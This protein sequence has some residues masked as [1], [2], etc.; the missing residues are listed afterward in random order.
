M[1]DILDHP[2][3]HLLFT[4]KGG[5]GKTSLAAAT[6]VA[7]AD[8]GRSV[9]LVSTDPASNL[10]QALECEVGTRVSPVPSVPGL[11][12]VN[13]DPAAA[14]EAYRER[15]IG[16]VRGVLP[17]DAVEQM[18]ESLSGACTTEIA[19]FD[20]FTGLLTDARLSR[21]FDH[22]VF[23]TAPTGHT[24]RLLQLPAAWS[25]FIE[26]NPDGAS[27]LGPASGL[28]AQRTQYASA[29][30]ALSDP[31]STTLVL[32]SRPERSALAEAARSASELSALGIRGRH[33]V[34]NG[35][36][37]PAA[38]GDPLADAIVTR[39]RAALA[40]RPASLRELPTERVG[41]RAH[42]LVGVAALR[43]LVAGDV[44]ASAGPS[45]DADPATM[46][47]LPPLQEL[48]DE[49]EADGRGLVMV[50]GKGGVG[51]TTIAAAL[52]V[53]LARRGHPVHLSTTDPAAHLEHALATEVE[54]L[55]VA[56]IDP[57]A[58]TRR[59]TERVL[60][61]KGKGLDDEGRRL[62]REDLRSPCTEEVAVFHAFSA[63][64]REAARGFV[65]L[66]TAPT[67]HTLPLLDQTGAYDREV[68]RNVG[69][70]PGRI[71]TPLARL[72]DPAYTR[73]LIATLPET[74]PVLEAAALQADLRR[75]GIEPCA[76]VVNRSLAA[77][78][79]TDP[80]LVARARAELPLLEA[81]A[82]EHAERA[83]VAPAMAREPV[84]PEALRDLMLGRER[85]TPAGAD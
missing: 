15:V 47:D 35:V 63:V 3:R 77:A 20:V 21:E 33:L 39:Q 6:A 76:W 30:E 13:V 9:L 29:V 57:A 7:L 23:D 48:A 24:L 1:L 37:E 40:E 16:P 18:T 2:T 52:A 41:L 78:Q 68:R 25:D 58:E 54:G 71:T 38:A 70:L 43:A 34:I 61:T 83:L 81:I 32:V 12:T 17:D 66:D 49:I 67:G 44:G 14:A 64:V 36:F 28:Q 79:P 46:P 62:L 19:S 26:T 69:G 56:R 10:G 84:G 75:A 59:Y 55:T 65:V 8:A 82:A 85:H 51:K 5:V 4:G 22:I 50:M 73:I 27:C 74:T 45:L 80:L 53:E 31:E 11:S 42:N 60:A 72:R